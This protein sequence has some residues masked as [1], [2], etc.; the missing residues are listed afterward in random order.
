MNV[1]LALFYQLDQP[2]N[3]PNVVLGGLFSIASLLG[4]RAINGMDKRQNDMEARVSQME[5]DFNK[6]LTRL[7][8]RCALDL[9]N[10]HREFINEIK[11]LR[12]EFRKDD[13]DLRDNI[14]IN[15]QD[16]ARLLERTKNLKT[17]PI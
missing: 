2:I 17:K 4:K 3:W 8:E 12:D 9:S 14:E 5:K 13:L 1:I 6:Q 10:N 7:S 16:I 11:A 15:S